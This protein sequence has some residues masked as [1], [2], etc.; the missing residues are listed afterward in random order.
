MA[1]GAEA[2]VGRAGSVH[3]MSDANSG[4]ALWASEAG[5]SNRNGEQ[6]RVVHQRRFV[7]SAI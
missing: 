4:M 2:I 1:A 7:G 3:L 5:N 6:R